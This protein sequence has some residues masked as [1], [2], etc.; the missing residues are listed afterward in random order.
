MTE[1]SILFA[2]RIKDNPPSNLEGLFNSAIQFLTLEEL[3]KIEFVIKFDNDDD[4]RPDGAFLSKWPFPVK[5]VTFE[6]GEGRHDINHFL[7][8]LFTLRDR[9]SRFIINLA[10]DFI[11]TRPNFINEIL[12]VKDSYAVMG[13]AR[14]PHRGEMIIPNLR[15]NFRD[16]ESYISGVAE[17]C[18]IIS[19]RVIE[20]VQN[21]GWQSSID[22]WAVMLAVG[23]MGK[24]QTNI[25][26]NLQ[27][28]YRRCDDYRTHH[29]DLHAARYV[30]NAME[31]SAYQ[32]CKNPYYYDL[33]EQQ[34]TNIYLNMKNEGVL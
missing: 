24:Y 2:S 10:D 13:G 17:Y 23:M 1:V 14:C 27:C 5:H 19:T 3:S 9:S 11:F 33:V 16:I 8:Y 32:Q 25:W 26:H 30:Y 28:F 18:P 21:I 4:G 31:W 12:S 6:R 15:A 34:I 20:A 29:K 22:V 7:N